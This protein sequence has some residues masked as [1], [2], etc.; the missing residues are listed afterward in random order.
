MLADASHKPVRITETL[1]ASALG[2]GMTAAFGAGWFSSIA[3]AASQMVGHDT[4]VIEPHAAASERYAALLD[5]YEKV[6]D[7]CAGINRLLVEF[8][9]ENKP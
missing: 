8:A 2:A 7:A 5:I 6:Y 4:Q 3:E 9:K 1:E